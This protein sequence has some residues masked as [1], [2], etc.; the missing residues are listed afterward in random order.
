MEWGIMHIR[1]LLLKVIN[2]ERKILTHYEY[3]DHMAEQTESVITQMHKEST[4]WIHP[5][6]RRP[7]FSLAFSFKFIYFGIV[8]IWTLKKGFFQRKQETIYG[9]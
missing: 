5:N 2:N 7:G 6:L 9:H 1:I 4:F 3:I 8:D